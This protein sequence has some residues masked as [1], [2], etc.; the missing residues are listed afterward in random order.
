VDDLARVLGFSDDELAEARALVPALLPASRGGRLSR[1]TR[2]LFDLQALALDSRR[3]DPIDWVEWLRSCGARPIERPMPWLREVMVLRHLASAVERLGLVPSHE[4]SRLGD[5]LEARLLRLRED[6]RARL[7]PELE[8]TLDEVGLAPDGVAERAA[9]AE[10]IDELFERIFRRGATDF[11]DLR[12][13]IARHPLKLP[14]L[15]GGRTLGWVPGLFRG[16]P[17]LHLDGRLAEVLDGVHYRG[18][19]YIRW[20][21]RAQSVLFGT[22]G[23]R[24]LSRFLLLPFGVAYI[25]LEFLAYLAHLLGARVDLATPFSIFGAGVVLLAVFEV[26]TLRQL[27]SR[28]LRGLWENATVRDPEAPP[29]ARARARGA[30]GSLV[31]SFFVGLASAYRDVVDRLDSTLYVVDEWLRFQAGEGR[32][33]RVVIGVFSLVWF[34]LGYGIRFFFKLIVEPT[35]NPVKHFPVVTVASKLIVASGASIVFGNFLAQY[36]GMVTAQLISFTLI[37]LFLPGVAGFL[38]W[39]VRFNWR[40]YAV[41]RRPLLSPVAVG[42]HGETLTRLLR[43]GFYSGTV[44]K[45]YKR[46]ARLEARHGVDSAQVR[47]VRHELEDIEYALLRFS[48]GKLLTFLRS[49]RAFAGREF[50]ATRVH[51]A[52]SELVFEW[53]LAGESSP[54]CAVSF[55]IED[56]VLSASVRDLG[57]LATVT[58]N[59]R[60]VFEAALLGFFA[61][62]G[63]RRVRGM[64]GLTVHWERWVL[65]WE[66]EQRGDVRPLLDGVR[67]FA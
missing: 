34:I 38:A 41:N 50:S 2:A 45:L 9:R 14:D 64:G 37:V 20:L 36:M 43:P 26:G 47:H 67:L 28:T 55:R 15:G 25:T 40:L 29:S 11:S 60:R 8:Q 24:A 57:F 27:A 62:A 12:D 54:P 22:P 61:G 21:H 51:V 46:L 7:T 3:P 17:L 33:A 59:A 32:R 42:L 10:L 13:A 35:F 52:S 16:D 56:R 63:A 53:S 18:E 5:L 4:A 30:R 31:G 48:E 39:E 65:F 6:V 19:F 49:S 1:E 58:P 44:P 66:A 23:G